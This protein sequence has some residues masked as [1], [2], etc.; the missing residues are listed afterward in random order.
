MENHYF[1]LIKKAWQHAGNRKKHYF[2][3]YVL[4][5]F[6]NLTGMLEPIFLAQ[7]FN[8]IQL[9]GSEGFTQ[10]IIYLT[11]YVSLSFFFW[12][13]HG[14]GRVIER[15]NTFYIVREFREQLFK[16]LAQLPLK[17]HKNHHSG[18]IMSRI[19]KASDALKRFVEDGFQF[20][21]TFANFIFAL[22]AIFVILPTA[23][24]VA[25]TIGAS[26]I[27]LVLYFDKKLIKLYDL[28]NKKWHIFDGTFYDYIGNIKTVITLRL[29]K[30]AQ[31]EIRKKINNLKSVWHEEV[32]I[33]EIKWF[34]LSMALAVL[35]FATLFVFVYLKMSTGQTILIGTLVALHQY[36]HRFR[37]TFFDFAWKYET[38]VQLNTDTK[39]ITHINNA[40]N[41]LVLNQR[42][43]KV[44]DFKQIEMNKLFFKYEDEEHRKHTLSDISISIKKGEKIAFIGESG[45]GKST[46]MSIL[47]GLENADRVELTIDNRKHNSLRAISDLVT[48]FPQDPEIFENTIEYNI[49][50]GI[51]HRK[52]DITEACTL[53]R[54]NDV[55]KRLPKGLQTDIKEKGVNLSGGEKQRLALARGIFAAQNSPL[56][57]LDE[58]TSSI[59]PQNE[60]IIYDNL[61]KKFKKSSIISAIHRLHLLPKFDTIYLFNQGKIVAYGNFDELLK[62]STLFKKMWGVYQQSLSTN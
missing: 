47:R 22:I 24:I 15:M 34:L 45:G 14:P 31:Q 40:Y 46:M 9:H 25:F 35:M 59:D 39:S 37:N 42:S 20:I 4:F 48:L 30:L 52:K 13:F 21:E 23:G 58:P 60:E 57:L 10:A 11:L 62:T 36:M 1:S 16:K 51:R 28:V 26:T 19:Q 3:S 17:W 6:A 38:I 55:L 29:E 12:A 27:G 43:K 2:F 54:F 53:A 33:N 7:F 56:I 49:S 18:T 8:T 32:V 44:T 50:A 41:K 61:F 5:I